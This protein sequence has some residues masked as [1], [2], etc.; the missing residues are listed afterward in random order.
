MS[1]FKQ[2][3]VYSSA[4]LNPLNLQGEGTKWE[5]ENYKAQTVNRIPTRSVVLVVSSQ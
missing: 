1:L 4:F 3:G 2:N 5:A